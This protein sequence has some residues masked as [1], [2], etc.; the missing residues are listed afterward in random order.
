MVSPQRAHAKRND[1]DRPAPLS[2]ERERERE[3]KGAR[4]G[5]DMR[6]PPFRDRGRA[7]ARARGGLGLMGRLVLNWLF[8]FPGNF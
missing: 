7:S 8:H 3:R 5:A 2:S 4:V 1:A 6:G